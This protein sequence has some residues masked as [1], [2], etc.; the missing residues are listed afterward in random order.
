MKED[1]SY[2]VL[3]L[4][5]LILFLLY[6]IIQCNK[7]KINNLKNESF[8][9]IPNRL[10]VNQYNNQK[11][12]KV[13]FNLKPD[14]KPN[15]TKLPKESHPYKFTKKNKTINECIKNNVKEYTHS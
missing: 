9:V 12:K 3:I 1:V 6:L 8:R 15:D 4:S 14:Y 10:Q 7:N 11:N 2:S 5:V 13:S